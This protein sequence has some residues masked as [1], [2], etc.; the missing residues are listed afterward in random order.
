MCR[1]KPRMKNVGEMFV[2]E[3]RALSREKASMV[4]G[5]V[6]GLLKG[7]GGVHRHYRC[8][9]FLSSLNEQ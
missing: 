9:R 3:C 7:V 1:V 6:A 5:W 2:S 8:S 4:S